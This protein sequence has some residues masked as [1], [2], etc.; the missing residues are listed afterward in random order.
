MDFHPQPDHLSRYYVLLPY[1]RKYFIAEDGD[2]HVIGGAGIAEFA[3]FDNCTELQKL[4]VADS[5]KG[6]G[7][8]KRLPADREA[9]IR[10]SFHH[11]PILHRRT[12]NPSRTITMIVPGA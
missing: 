6:K 1:K 2:R 12:L 7:I 8:G 4:Y 3:E 11:G 10:G 9:R 5:A